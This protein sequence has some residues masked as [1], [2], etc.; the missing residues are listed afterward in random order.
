MI[1][2]CLWT[3]PPMTPSDATMPNPLNDLARDLD[4]QE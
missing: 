1:D 3:P 2:A 4:S